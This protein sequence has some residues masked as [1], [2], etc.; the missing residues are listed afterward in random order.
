MS[1]D[2]K[3]TVDQA[4]EACNYMV[5]EVLAPAFFEKLSAYSIQPRNQAEATQL[6]ELGANLYQQAQ[7]GQLKTAAVRAQ[8]QAN[9]FLQHVLSRV[10]PAQAPTQ[11][12]IDAHIKTAA[13]QIAKKDPLAKTAALV[14]NYIMNGGQTADQPAA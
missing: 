8:E 13:V 11:A 14:Y 3:P 4:N 9:P 5:S 1:T 2:I 10:A 7:S 6:L 12:Q